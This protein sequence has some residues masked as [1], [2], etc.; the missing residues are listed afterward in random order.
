MVS[1]ER[2]PQLAALIS[3]WHI[4]ADAETAARFRCCVAAA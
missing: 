3:N 1:E 4:S 2:R